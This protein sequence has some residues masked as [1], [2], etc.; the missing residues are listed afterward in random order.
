ME[1]RKGQNQNGDINDTSGNQ[2]AGVGKSKTINSN[3]DFTGA[4]VATQSTKHV[5]YAIR[6]GGAV[7]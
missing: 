5:P 3:T 1:H 6:K 7:A 2:A 4:G